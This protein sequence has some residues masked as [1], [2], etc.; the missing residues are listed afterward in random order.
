M[1]L[2]GRHKGLVVIGLIFMIAGWLS[3]NLLLAE[4]DLPPPAPVGIDGGD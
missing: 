2:K 4:P 3:W 1:K